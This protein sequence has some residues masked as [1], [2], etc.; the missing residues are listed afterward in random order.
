LVS[1]ED[2]LLPLPAVTAPP[3]EEE[4]LGDLAQPVL[5]VLRREES[6]V[7]SFLFC[8]QEGPEIVREGSWRGVM[9]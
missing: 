6:G 1:V 2:P 4:P 9:M 3:P 8:V 5:G 7:G